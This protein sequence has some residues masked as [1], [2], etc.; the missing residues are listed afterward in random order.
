MGETKITNG[1]LVRKL[2]GRDHLKLRGG[3]I[4]L[5]F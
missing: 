1:I 5:T 2:F 3:R 4:I